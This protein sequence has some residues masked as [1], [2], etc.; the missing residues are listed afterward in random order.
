MIR[1]RGLF[2]SQS[3]SN[4]EHGDNARTPLERA[5]TQDSKL[6]TIRTDYFEPGKDLLS[7]ER[8]D[9]AGRQTSRHAASDALAAGN[10]AEEWRRYKK[11]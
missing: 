4:T 5:K 1:L 8:I 7:L 9:R 2:G 3:T 6:T 11:K 10:G